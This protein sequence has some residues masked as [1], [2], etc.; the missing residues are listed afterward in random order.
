M[1]IADPT[2]R[3]HDDVATAAPVLLVRAGQGGAK[4]QQ[5]FPGRLQRSEA[6]GSRLRPA[7]G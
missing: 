4:L 1:M 2:P 5:P 6:P 7:R 3:R